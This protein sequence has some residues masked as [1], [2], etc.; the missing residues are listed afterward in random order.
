[1]KDLSVFFKKH[2]LFQGLKIIKR[3]LI[4]KCVYEPFNV[5]RKWIKI[6]GYYLLLDFKTEG[7]SK[8]LYVM[9]SREILETEIMKKEIKNEDICLEAGANIGYYALL[10]AQ[11]TIGKIYAF[12]PDI[13]NMDILKKAIKR[14]NFKNIETYEMAL[15][16]K[17]GKAEIYLEEESNINSL[18]KEKDFKGKTK[19]INTTTIDNFFK[20]RKGPD[21]IR[22]D[23]EGFEYEVFSGMGSLIKSN[24]P[25]RIMVE[26]HFYKYT[27]K[28]DFTKKIKSLKENGFKVKYLITQDKPYLNLMR[29]KGYTPLKII[30]DSPNKRALYENVKMDDLIHLLKK[31]NIIRAGFFE[32]V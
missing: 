14:N 19:L 28:R 13:R 3:Y 31:G 18:I 15:S 25:L 1:M 30:N 10:E 21:F 24:K 20:K 23:I 11:K 29:S 6:N 5:K 27:P 16:N 17:I 4:M 12:E 8:G 2:G 22:M 9:G 7:I 26:F 32:R